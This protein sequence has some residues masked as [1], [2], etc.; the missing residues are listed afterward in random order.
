[1]S[2]QNDGLEGRLGG[3]YMR[4]RQSFRH[5]VLA[6]RLETA[7]TTPIQ[8][9]RKRAQRRRGALCLPTRT[10]RLVW[11]PHFRSIAY[12]YRISDQAEGAL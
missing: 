9:E 8:L 12:K 7:G 6:E 3:T 4:S 5:A 2:A 1:M 11:L 10:N